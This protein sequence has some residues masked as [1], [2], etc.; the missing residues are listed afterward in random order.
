MHILSAGAYI[1]ITVNYDCKKVKST[2]PQET[3]L[4]N[5]KFGCENYKVGLIRQLSEANS[6][7]KAQLYFGAKITAKI[8]EKMLTKMPAK[9]PMKMHVKMSVFLTFYCFYSV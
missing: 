8:P 7:V 6:R 3:V 4:K 9:M 5:D 1:A 2:F